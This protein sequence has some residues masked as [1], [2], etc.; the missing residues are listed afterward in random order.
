MVEGFYVMNRS[1]ATFTNEVSYLPVLQYSY[2][3]R[4][5][6]YSGSFNL[7]VWERSED[8]ATVTGQGWIGEK[9]R[10][11]YNPSDPAVSIWLQQEGAP[12]G[13]SSNLPYAS[14]DSVI[15]PQLNK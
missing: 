7:G 2:A 1:G 8:S 11:R 9:I 10:V 4:G 6:R 14:D 5:E 3:V 15:D 13:A 12:A